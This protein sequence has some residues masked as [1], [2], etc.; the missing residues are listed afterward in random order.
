M[1]N[2]TQLQL[3]CNSLGKWEGFFVT[4]VSTNVTKIKANETIPNKKCS[5]LHARKRR[6]LSVYKYTRV[7]WIGL[8]FSI[9]IRSKRWV[10]TQSY[11]V[12]VAVGLL[13]LLH[14]FLFLKIS[15]ISIQLYCI[16][17]YFIVVDILR[18]CWIQWHDI[19]IDITDPYLISS[20]H[21]VL[22]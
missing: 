14:F 6:K 16:V 19:D 5:N 9:F 20:Y 7:E 21:T 22:N 13:L 2:T 3:K 10:I 11:C 15:C 4:C 18:F 1:V 17:C 12:V 8:D